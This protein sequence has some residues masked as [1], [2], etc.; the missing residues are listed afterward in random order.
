MIANSDIANWRK[1]ITQ[2]G[3]DQTGEDLFI[4]LC[5]NEIE[6]LRAALE[7]IASIEPGMMEGDFCT[8]SYDCSACV[9]KIEIALA[10][11]KKGGE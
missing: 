5:L 3:D 4:L 6:R 2:K 1:H 9:E 10:A 11:L 8:T 7:K